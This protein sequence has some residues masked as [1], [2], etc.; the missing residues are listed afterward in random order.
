MCPKMLHATQARIVAT[1]ESARLSP[2]RLLRA[3]SFTQPKTQPRFCQSADAGT[4]LAFE[5]E[6]TQVTESK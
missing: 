3:M 1:I 4:C 6:I 2:L 5:K